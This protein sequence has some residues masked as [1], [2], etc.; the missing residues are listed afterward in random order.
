M[1][2][3]KNTG[4]SEIRGYLIGVL[5]ER[6][7]TIWGSKLIGTLPPH[8]R[9]DPQNENSRQREVQAGLRAYG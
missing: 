3:Q 6:N 8:M 4:V 1:N 5:I 7:P 9:H 2:P